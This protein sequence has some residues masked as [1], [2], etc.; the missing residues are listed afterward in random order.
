M[1]SGNDADGYEFSYNNNSLSGGG[2][3]TSVIYTPKWN[4]LVI[5]FVDKDGEDFIYD[6]TNNYFM[7]FYHKSPNSSD[8]GMERVKSVGSKFINAL[9]RDR[10]RKHK[11]HNGFTV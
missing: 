9:K 3:S 10:A 5:I 1:I 6:Y 11:S 4:Q 8:E 2:K 7:C